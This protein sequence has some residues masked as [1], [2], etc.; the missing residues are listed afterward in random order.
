MVE[1]RVVLELPKDAED[2]GE[3]MPLARRLASAGLCGRQGRVARG[4]TCVKL[5]R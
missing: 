2:G 5:Q 3:M 1:E 4:P